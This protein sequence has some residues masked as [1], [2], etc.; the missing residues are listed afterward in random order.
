MQNKRD[1]YNNSAIVGSGSRGMEDHSAAQ[2]MMI[3]N[4]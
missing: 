3:Q 2:A 1:K 4:N